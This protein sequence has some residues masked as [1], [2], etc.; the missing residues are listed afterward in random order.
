MLVELAVSDLGVI[1]SLTLVFGSGMTAQS[2]NIK[3]PS[4]PKFLFL[5]TNTVQLEIFS[6]PGSGLINWMIGRNT[7]LATE[8]T[9]E[10]SPSAC[11]YCTI[12]A[13]K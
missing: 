9:P 3:T 4:S 8:F 11:E 2:A 6:V 5:K 10:T 13:A 1:D 7:V 12:I